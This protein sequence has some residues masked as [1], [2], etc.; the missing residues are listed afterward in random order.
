[1]TYGWDDIVRLRPTR[2]QGR[3]GHPYEEDV[4]RRVR[5]LWE[6]TWLPSR[7]VARRAGV[8]P[9]TA[10]RWARDGGWLRP[11]GAPRSRDLADTP[12]ARDRLRRRTA[13]ARALQLAE[14]NIVELEAS[15]VID[16]PLL[17]EALTMLR[18]SV[19]A[20]A[21]GTRRRAR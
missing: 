20:R 14:R 21:G 12:R 11:D 15:G 18:L 10:K 3:S 19:E 6:T 4:V 13:P 17:A 9:T 16:P 1:M 2:P 7:E 8:S 5:A